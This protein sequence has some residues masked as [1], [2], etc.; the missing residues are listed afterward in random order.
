MAALFVL[1]APGE[2]GRSSPAALPGLAHVCC[3]TGVQDG[4]VPFPECVHSTNQGF[5]KFCS[6]GGGRPHGAPSV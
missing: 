3:M 1:V 2:V 4:K 6:S 5:Q